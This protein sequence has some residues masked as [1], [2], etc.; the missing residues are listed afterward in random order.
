MGQ[1]KYVNESELVFSEPRMPLSPIY[2]MEILEEIN[3]LRTWNDFV[4]LCDKYGDWLC[5]EPFLNKKVGA[6]SMSTGHGIVSATG[7]LKGNLVSVADA[8]EDVE[9]LDRFSSD[10]HG[11]ESNA[12]YNSFV[13]CVHGGVYPYR[14]I[15]TRQMLKYLR[16]FPFVLTLAAIANGKHNGSGI[17]E[18][19]ERVILKLGEEPSM[20]CPVYIALPEELAEN[21]MRTL[22]FT[23]EANFSQLPEAEALPERQRVSEAAGC[24]RNAPDLSKHVRVFVFD[25]ASTLALSDEDRSYAVRQACG[26]LACF[27][28]ARIG[29]GEASLRFVNG[30]AVIDGEATIFQVIA[31]AVR[32]ILLDDNAI[33]CEVCSRP[34]LTHKDRGTPSK[35]CH[36][37]SCKTT[38]S[39]RRKT[40]V[41]QLAASGVPVEDAVSELGGQYRQSIERW[42]ENHVSKSATGALE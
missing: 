32:K 6:F 26:T 16:L 38:A 2:G 27:V 25:L 23:D 18:A 11:D 30:K 34:V 21:D 20:A 19:G 40:R 29:F 13:T 37:G 14:V 33:L 4:T 41:E 7:M 28:L 39:A 1:L 8:F 31:Q 5:Y 35:V 22:F 36:V 42:Y 12:I 15:E 3:N 24:S 9:Y 17:A 10:V